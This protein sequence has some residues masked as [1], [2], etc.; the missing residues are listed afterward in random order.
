M[1]KGPTHEYTLAK[2]QR[3]TYTKEMYK[4][5]NFKNTQGDTKKSSPYRILLMPC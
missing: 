5:I 2:S 1:S 3:T 4:K